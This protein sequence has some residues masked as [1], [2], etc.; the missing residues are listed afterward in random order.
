MSVCFIEAICICFRKDCQIFFL[1]SGF[2]SSLFS[3]VTVVT[4]SIL[5]LFLP[6][7]LGTITWDP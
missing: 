6:Q 1:Y 3:H 2:N 5:T 7:I 4:S